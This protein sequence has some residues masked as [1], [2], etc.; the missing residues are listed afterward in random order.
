MDTRLKKISTLVFSAIILFSQTVSLALAG[1]IPAFNI[2]TPYTHTQASNQDYYLL[3]IKNETKGSAYSGS[4]SADPGDIL[5]FSV[6]YHNGAI[7]SIAR[8]TKIKV[9]IPTNTGTQIVSTAFLWADNASNATYNNPFTGTATVNISSSQKLEYITGS[10]K[11]YPRRTNP[12]ADASTN[13]P[14][15]QSG[16]EIINSNG[17][18]IGDIEGCW[19]NSGFI[20]FKVRVGNV[21][22]PTPIPPT[23]VVR[24]VTG[25]GDIASTAAVAATSAGLIIFAIYFLLKH[26][27]ILTKIRLNSYTLGRRLTEKI[28]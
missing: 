13:F 11:W 22:P 3:D 18:F 12:G 25:A 8:N 17:V 9:A 5:I 16:D 27:S 14:N 10:A 24:A 1:D 20:N 4:V 15:S 6:F 7:N 19:E 23:P 2:H 28:S 21:L 26:N